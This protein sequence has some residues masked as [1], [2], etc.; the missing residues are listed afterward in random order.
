MVAV[1]LKY[2]NHGTKVSKRFS[3]I[4]GNAPLGYT[5]LIVTLTMM[6]FIRLKIADGQ[7]K[8]NKQ[9]TAVLPKEYSHDRRNIK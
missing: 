5:R 3:E 8:K 9:L 2:A 7:L 6:E 4:W 1:A